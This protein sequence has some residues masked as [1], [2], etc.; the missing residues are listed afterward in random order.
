[1]SL[2]SAINIS[3]TYGNHKALKDIS[4]KVNKGEIVAL[5]GKNGAGK[6]T[7][8]KCISGDIKPNSGEILYKNKSILNYSYN[9][10]DFGILIQANFL[11]YL[12]AYDNLALLMK[13]SGVRDR[14]IIKRKVD[15]IL[16]LVD[17]EKQKYSYVKTFSFGMKQRLGLAQALI[18]NPK[19]LILDEPFVGLD[20]IGKNILKDIIIK[21][22]KEENVGIIISSHD[23][24]DIGEICDRIVVFD[25]GEKVFDNIFNFNK[26]YMIFIKEM[27]STDINKQCIEIFS[28]RV[29]IKKQTFEFIDNCI[30]DEV[31]SFIKRSGLEI[32]DIK[33]KENSLYDFFDGEGECKNE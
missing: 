2:F 33:I 31:I 32:L 23:L 18:N 26:K 9:L 29:E 10:N 15:E 19:F 30:I 21:K 28:D 14:N 20:P 17:L 7:F 16:R 3:K 12:N 24:Y 1:M 13:A 22:A 11:D 27:V 4:F 5:I 8:L 25:E 6:S